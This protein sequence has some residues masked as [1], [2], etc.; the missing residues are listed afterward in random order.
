MVT[1]LASLFAS[2]SR[3]RLAAAYAAAGVTAGAVSYGF[4]QSQN[5]DVFSHA[6]RALLR[7]DD[8]YVRRAADYFKYSPTFALLFLPF[9][10]T[11]AWLSSVLWSLLNFALAFVGIDR[12]VDD[13]RQKRVAML[14]ALAGIVLATDGDQSNLLV[15]GAW[16]LAFDAFERSRTRAG[17]TFVMFGAFVKIFPLLAG[18]FAL[19][20]PRRARTFA[21]LGVAAIAWAAI[22]LLVCTPQQLV[23]EYA[24]WA[25][26]VSWDHG[27]RGWS[28]LPLFQDELRLSWGNL[29]LQLAGAAVQAVPMILGLRFGTD[30]VWRRTLACSLLV[31]AVLFNHRTE[32]CSFV[33]SAIAVGVW[34]ATVRTSALARALVVLSIV[35]PGPFFARPDPHLGGAFAFLAAHREFHV[36]RVVPLLALWLFMQKDLL[37]RFVRVELALP[38]TASLESSRG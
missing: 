1:R 8:L 33:V 30:Q 14:V 22:P 34:C 23:A 13:P 5:F 6:A 16:L 31:F 19:F 17:A 10:W 9:T 38:R 3:A 4:G 35:A 25:N 36:L 7:G 26:L 21:A 32:Y 29:A 15:A 27:N 11:P 28:A 18:A 20:H 37:K 2:L 24:S 12:V